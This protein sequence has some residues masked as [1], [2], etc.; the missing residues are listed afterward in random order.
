MSGSSS[1]QKPSITV[2]QI[3]MKSSDP[4]AKHTI[5]DVASAHT[6]NFQGG[7]GTLNSVAHSVAGV[8]AG[9][10]KEA[11]LRKLLE[12]QDNYIYELEA[13]CKAMSAQL[14]DLPYKS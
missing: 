9:S 2:D 6:G 7:Y 3:S 5:N 1:R 11:V 13:K 14:I 8:G 12:T 10:G 4:S